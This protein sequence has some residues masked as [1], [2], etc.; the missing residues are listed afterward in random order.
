MATSPISKLFGQSDVL[1]RLQDHALHL[2]RL[3]RILDATLP[4]ATR[5]SAHIANLQ[6]GELIVHV[7]SPAMATRLRLCIESLK[8]ALQTHGEAVTAIR[9]K[10]RTV[11]FQGDSVTTDAPDRHIGAQGKDALRRLGDSLGESDPLA[12]ALKRM[13]DRSR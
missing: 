9:I 13:I 11:R 12:L 2:L 4:P 3:Q 8:T 6:E 5:G 10:V 7:Q 1:A